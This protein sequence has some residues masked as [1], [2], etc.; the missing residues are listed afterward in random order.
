M[1]RRC[2][3]GTALW[4][5]GSLLAKP[6]AGGLVCATSPTALACTGQQPACTFCHS[7]PPQ[8]NVTSRS[9]LSDASGF[10]PTY[11]RVRLRARGR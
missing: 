11:W 9:G 2:I 7:A 3:G 1:I 4:L 6:S 10:L 8:R 5:R